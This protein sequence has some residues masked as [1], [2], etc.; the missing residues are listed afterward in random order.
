MGKI[1]MECME[2]RHVSNKDLTTPAQQFICS[3]GNYATAKLVAIAPLAIQL[4]CTLPASWGNKWLESEPAEMLVGIIHFIKELVPSVSSTEWMVI[5]LK[6]DRGLRQFS[7]LL[8]PSTPRSVTEVRMRRWPIVEEGR[9][10][11]VDLPFLQTDQ[12]R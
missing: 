7:F 10:G 3:I 2:V 4:E 9:M 6:E 8:T 1:L 5:T 12:Q 11:E